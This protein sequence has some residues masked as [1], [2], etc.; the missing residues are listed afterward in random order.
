VDR[1]RHEH[2]A[3]VAAIDEQRVADAR[4][5]VHDHITGYYASAN[6]VRPDAT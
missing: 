1:L 5:A 6:P 4:T 2:Y 3:I